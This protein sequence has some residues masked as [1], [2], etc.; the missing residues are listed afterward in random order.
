MDI[1][2]GEVKFDDFKKK[3]EA[4]IVSRLN[5]IGQEG[6]KHA[7]LIPKDI[8]YEDQTGNLR[9][10]TGYAVGVGEVV[11]TQFE[12]VRGKE[13]SNVE[14]TEVG[15]SV[16]EE[17]V[18][19]YKIPALTITAGMEYASELEARGRDV[20]TSTYFKVKNELPGHLKELKENIRWYLKR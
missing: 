17:G 11:N 1:K 10:S 7:R 18:R 12:K 8:G 4:V 16:A 2:G 15:R 20:L 19:K 6:T 5:L 13:P 9:S 14:G 3:V